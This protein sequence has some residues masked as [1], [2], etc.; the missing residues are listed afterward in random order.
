MVSVKASQ[1]DLTYADGV[2]VCP[3]YLLWKMPE[4]VRAVITNPATGFQE[5]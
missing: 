5:R 3:L 1:A 4:L 2:L